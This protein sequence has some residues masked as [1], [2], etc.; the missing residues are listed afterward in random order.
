MCCLQMADP[1]LQTAPLESSVSL[2]KGYY[3]APLHCS[4]G[5]VTVYVQQSGGH[6]EM[7]SLSSPSQNPMFFAA[8]PSATLEPKISSSSSAWT[9]ADSQGSLPQTRAVNNRRYERMP[10]KSRW[11]P[12]AAQ[13]CLLEQHFNSGALVGRLSKP[14]ILRVWGGLFTTSKTWT[15]SKLVCSLSLCFLT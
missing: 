15:I 13:L 2:T 3:A 10:P 11:K 12:N 1:L 7:H 8:Q 5:M 6:S 9:L 14:E 4:N